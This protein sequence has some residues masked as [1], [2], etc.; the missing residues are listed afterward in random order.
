MA[1]SDH[2]TSQDQIEDESAVWLSSIINEMWP[3]A[4]NVAQEIMQNYVQ[5]ALQSAIP[6]G[7]PTPRFKTIDF[8]TDSVVVNSIRVS[9][10]TLRASGQQVN[11]AGAVIRDERIEGTAVIV[12]ADISYEGKPTIE[13]TL[14]DKLTFGVTDA[15]LRGRV[16][17]MLRPIIGAIPLF[18]ASQVAFI[19]RPVLDYNLT[20]LA[21]LGNTAGLRDIIRRTVD[22]VL[23]EMMV[24]PNRT[25][26]KIVPNTDFFSYAAQPLGVLRVAV[27]SGTGFPATDRN[28]LKQAVG[29]SEEPDVYLNLKHGHTYYNTQHINSNSDPVWENQV[30]D[31]VIT[32]ES[33]SQYLLLEGYDFD[34][35]INN[36]DFLGKAAI[37]VKDLVSKPVTRVFLTDSPDNA[38]PSVKIAARYL[39][40]S[41][42][43]RHVQNA[44]ISQ[45]A[46]VNLPENCASIL[47]TV[48]IDECHGLPSGKRPFV[49]V[50]IGPHTLKTNAAYDVPGVFNVEDA[51]FEQSFYVPLGKKIDGNMQIK[52]SVVDLFSGEVMGSA[53]SAMAEVIEADSS[54]KVY[55]FALIGAANVG[56]SLRVRVSLSAVLDVPPMWTQ[57]G[58]LSDETKYQPQVLSS[59]LT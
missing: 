50:E 37:L 6:K 12:E 15:K 46:Q 10:R 23:A 27:L 32:T 1:S 5:P 29:F 25:A 44:I 43:L 16:E 54:G 28:F 52:Y 9:E 21:A 34:I 58:S 20:G 39:E 57:L 22:D 3:Y 26:Y 48:D 35:G 24:L 56:A 45:Q 8:G 33:L 14:G 55:K 42:D 41:S 18:A 13:M 49:K 17:V 30:F 11:D 51:E 4:A 40:L 36:D 47:L 31:F 59:I 2:F 38:K 19:N 7:F 53:Y